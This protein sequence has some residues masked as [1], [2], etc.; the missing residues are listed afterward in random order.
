MDIFSINKNQTFLIY[1]LYKSLLKLTILSNVSSRRYA[2]RAMLLML[3]RQ[4]AYSS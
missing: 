3:A 4:Q 1:V 2:P